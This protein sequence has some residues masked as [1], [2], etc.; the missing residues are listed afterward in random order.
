MYF[1]GNNIKIYNDYISKQIQSEYGVYYFIKGEKRNIFVYG[2]HHNPKFTTVWADNDPGEPGLITGSTTEIG[3][4]EDKYDDETSYTAPIGIKFNKETWQYGSRFKIYGGA[5][6]NTERTEFIIEIPKREYNINFSCMTG[7]NLFDINNIYSDK[8]KERLALAFK[9]ANTDI[10][11]KSQN[12]DLSLEIINIP[13]GKTL[14]GRLKEWAREKILPINYLSLTKNSVWLFVVKNF[15][16]ESGED[17]L[18]YGVTIS[19]AN[20]NGEKLRYCFIFV[21]RINFGNPIETKQAVAS[22]VIHE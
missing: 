8:T 3:N 18:I 17:P 20:S 22:T 7:Y 12:L 19:D 5:S 21:D 6:K 9:D 15:Y 10:L 11:I 16:F 13:L 4:S 2:R 1:E 14:Y